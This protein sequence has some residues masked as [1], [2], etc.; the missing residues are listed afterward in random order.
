M[1]LFTD[2]SIQTPQLFF[3]KFAAKFQQIS[4]KISPK[5]EENGATEQ[6]ENNT[7]RLLAICSR[8]LPYVSN[9]ATGYNITHSTQL[10]S[11]TTFSSLISVFV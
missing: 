7:D 1:S 2:N 6:F 3:Y 5:C 9:T 11:I 8:N 4:Q 10:P